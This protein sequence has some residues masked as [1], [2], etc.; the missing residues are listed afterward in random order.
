MDECHYIRNH[1]V[2]RSDWTFIIFYGHIIQYTYT[3]IQIHRRTEER[4]TVLCPPPFW[5][6]FLRISQKVFI[7]LKFG[8][9]L[10]LAPPFPSFSV[11]PLN[12]QFII[13]NTQ[14]AHYKRSPQFYYFFLFSRL[15]SVYKSQFTYPNIKIDTHSLNSPSPSLNIIESLSLLECWQWR[16]WGWIVDGAFARKLTQ[17]SSE[18]A[19]RAAQE[20]FQ[21]CV[22]SVRELA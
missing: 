20:T 19:R 13:V 1:F 16:F 21:T 11:R 4:S 7:F 15:H 14:N 9:P 2:R 3:L 17:P 10:G 6:I 5:E 8:P 18:P 12:I 22:T